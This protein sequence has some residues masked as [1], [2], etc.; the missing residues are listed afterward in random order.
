MTPRIIPVATERQLNDAWRGHEQFVRGQRIRRRRASRSLTTIC[1]P[2]VRG[3]RAPSALRRASTERPAMGRTAARDRDGRR[4]LPHLDRHVDRGDATRHAARPPVARAVHLAR[5]GVDR[6]AQ[7]GR[8]RHPRPTARLDRGSPAPRCRDHDERVLATRAVVGVLGV[9]RRPAVTPVVRRRA[10]RPAVRCPH[11]VEVPAGGAVL[12]PRL[13]VPLQRG[14][15][16]V[17]GTVHRA[18]HQRPRP[19]VAVDP[20]G[21]TG[22]RERLALRGDPRGSSRSRCRWRRLARVPTDSSASCSSDW[23]SCSSSAGVAD[24]RRRGWRPGRC[25][26]GSST[27]SASCSSS[28]PRRRYGE[29]VAIEGFHPYVGLVVFN[30]AVLV[31]M[32]LMRPFGLGS[33]PSTKAATTRATMA[34]RT[35]CRASIARSHGRPPRPVAALAVTAAVHRRR[36]LQRRPTQLRPCGVEPRRGPADE[37]RPEPGDTREGGSSRP[38]IPTTGRSAS[39]ATAPVGQVPLLRIPGAPTPNSP[40]TYRSPST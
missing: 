35:P 17:A 4:R 20:M 16:E 24:A 30:V 29:D 40:P 33:A 5:L 32:M 22:C 8:S 1:H 23:R 34:T 13:A 2:R 11:A 10:R 27:S 37:L 21:R 25:S 28:G 38:P 26:C 15:H 39:S 31:M 3:D 19:R 6:Q 18:H 14:A 9:A 7:H 12:V 36:D